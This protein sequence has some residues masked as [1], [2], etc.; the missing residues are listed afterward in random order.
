MGGNFQWRVC[1]DLVGIPPDRRK[2]STT[3]RYSDVVQLDFELA[4]GEAYL[5]NQEPGTQTA[6]LLVSSYGLAVPCALSSFARR[7]QAVMSEAYIGLTV[8]SRLRASHYPRLVPDVVTTSDGVVV[9]VTRHTYVLYNSTGSQLLEQ[10]DYFDIDIA[11]PGISQIS[12]VL[13]LPVLAAIRS[14]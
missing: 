7:L 13:E 14:S 6:F 11:V 1:V 3:Q 8:T 10:Y 12:S 2:R 9:S 5:L 4:P